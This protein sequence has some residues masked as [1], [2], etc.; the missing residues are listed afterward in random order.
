MWDVVDE[1]SDTHADISEEEGFLDNQVREAEAIA[2]ED[3][4]V[5]DRGSEDCCGTTLV[6][7]PSVVYR[8]IIF[9]DQLVS[10]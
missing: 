9:P 2:E 7:A 3:W 8:S 5:K 10:D 1:A 4:P 6:Q